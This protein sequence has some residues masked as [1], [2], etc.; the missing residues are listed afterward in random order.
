MGAAADRTNEEKWC[1]ERRAHV[2]EYLAGER[3]EH[4]RVGDWPAWHLA[5]YV[6]IWAIE[7]KKNR[8]SV[9]WW[10][11]SG[12]L[13]TDYVSAKDAKDPREAMCAI[14]KRWLVQAASMKEGKTLPGMQ[15]GRTEDR[16]SLAPLLESKAST[17]LKWANDDAVW[18]DDAL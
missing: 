13:P 10:V 15:L 2:T 12:D 18:D 1:A 5:P 11:I 4:G 6:S 7:S 8:N 9:G 14:A 3:V 16:E 17:L